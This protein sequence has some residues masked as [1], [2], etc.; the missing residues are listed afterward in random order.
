MTTVP[1]R[2][3][4]AIDVQDMGVRY[5]LRLAKKNTLRGG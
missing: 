1:A 2:H 3:E 4:Y 5:N